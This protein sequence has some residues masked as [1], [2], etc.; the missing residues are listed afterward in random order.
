MGSSKGAADRRL[1]L[2]CIL[3]SVAA[4][5]V[6][7]V[8]HGGSGPANIYSDISSFWGRSW[9]SSGQVPY[10]S[11]KAFLEYPPISGGILYAARVIGGWVAGSS[12][13]K[14]LGSTP[15]YEGYFDAFAAFSIAAAAIIGWST[16]RLAKALGVKLYP[17]YFLL[18]SFLIF[19]VY[20]FDLFN[21]LFIVLGLQL[22]VEGRKDLSALAIGAAIATKL[23]AVVLVPIFLFESAGWKPRLRY[24][25]VS[26]GAAAA[27]FV[28]IAIFNWGFFSQFISFYQGWGLEDAWTIWIFGDPF[29]A[30]AKVFGIVLMA[31]LLVKVYLT[32]MPLVERCFLA[33]A[34]YLFATT[35][36]APQFVVMLVPL[37]AVLAIDSPWLFSMEAANALII[38]TWFTVP[39][40]THAGTLPQVFA[41]IRSASLGLL[42][43]SVA[44]GAGHPISRRLMS[45]LKLPLGSKSP[46][47]LRQEAEEPSQRG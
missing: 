36:F 4:I 24:V 20:N 39:D 16:W 44:S 37:V 32:K 33:L 43:L 18:P 23:V 30:A 26:L 5:I 17:L 7:A 34:S 22:Y 19:G 6:S 31:V 12:L 3:T 2:S 47:M 41:L 45:W 11:S 13:G 9:V 8:I 42:G 28:P 29:S 15:L 10:S 40:P 46:G 38:L 1:L 14:Y 35:V 27:T 25:A 21:A